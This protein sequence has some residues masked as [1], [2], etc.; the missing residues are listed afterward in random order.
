M[1]GQLLGGPERRRRKKKSNTATP[2]QVSAGGEPG[3]EAL[4]VILS[5]CF[6]LWPSMTDHGLS[7]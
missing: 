6:V 2:C 1:V 3:E 5:Q 7:D 4:D